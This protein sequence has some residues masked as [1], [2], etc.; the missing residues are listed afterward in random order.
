MAS[1]PATITGGAQMAEKA[2]GTI[3]IDADPPTVLG[4]ITDFESY[5]QWATGVKNIEVLERDA[6]GRGIAV[7]F[8]VSAVGMNGWYI[9]NY[10]YSAGAD[11]L[12]WTFQEGSP[13]KDL[14]GE[15]ELEADG[16]ATG[17]TYR[18]LVE[19]GIPMIGFMKRQVSKMIID[20]A[21]KGLKKRV[22]SLG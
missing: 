10:D 16:D 9:L 18:A 11:G 4:V 17:V 12:S 2:E 3:T 8:E 1:E 7:R 6:H 5:P 22:E 21:L 15:Y 14:Q 13:I 20:T 19:P